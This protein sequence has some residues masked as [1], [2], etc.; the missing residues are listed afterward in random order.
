MI[1]ADHPYVYVRNNPV[2]FIDPLGLYA[3]CGDHEIWGYICFDSTQVGLSPCD[4]W[5]NCYIWSPGGILWLQDDF[6]ALGPLAQP[7]GVLI[8]PILMMIGTALSSAGSTIRSC[9]LTSAGLAYKW[10]CSGRALSA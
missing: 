4:I 5:G 8:H 9:L 1:M 7:A 3:I 2:R 10:C 6:A